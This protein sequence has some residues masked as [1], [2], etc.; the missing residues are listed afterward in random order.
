[1][2]ASNLAQQ[3]LTDLWE[4]GR[5]VLIGGAVAFIWSSILKRSEASERWHFQTLLILINLGITGPFAAAVFFNMEAG[6]LITLMKIKPAWGVFTGLVALVVLLFLATT[7]YMLLAANRSAMPL[8][9]RET[10]REL[11]RQLYPRKIK[12]IAL[13]LSLLVSS[14]ILWLSRIAQ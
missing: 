1:M 13:V 4:V 10:V 7:G 5:V 8:S 3:I 6:N 12:L 2:D 11:P 14:S 9:I